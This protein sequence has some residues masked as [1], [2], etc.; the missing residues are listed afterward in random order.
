[1]KISIV[2]DNTAYLS[3]LQPD[4][5]FACLIQ[6]SGLPRLLFDTGANGRIL[7]DNMEK[8]G[9][10]PRDIDI[11]FISHGHFDHAG[12]L[13]TFL[14]ANTQALVYVPSSFKTGGHKNILSLDKP[15]KIADHM[16]S[17]GEL[18]GIEQSL[19]LET[20]DYALL[21]TGCSHPGLDRILQAVAQ[22]GKV[23]GIVGGLHGFA[24]FQLLKDMQWICPTH[25]TLYKAEIES[26][27]PDKYLPGGAGQVISF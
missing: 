2:Y 15:Q 19:V 16:Y 10:D 22:L 26:L 21:V 24:D 11:V 17:T 3:Y 5:G 13:Q 6:D 8:M 12:G 18:A 14:Q 25:C 9:I 4:W 27:Y 20:G 7:L 1:M 23:S